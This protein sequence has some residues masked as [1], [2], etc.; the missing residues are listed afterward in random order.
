MSG[1]LALIVFLFQLSP[2]FLPVLGTLLSSAV[3]L[4]VA[5]S[6]IFLRRQGFLVYIGAAFMLICVSPM[7]TV[8][9]LLTTGLSGLSLGLCYWRKP[10]FTFLISSF[11][12]AAGMFCLTYAAGN[13]TLN[14]LFRNMPILVS[15]PFFAVFSMIYMGVWLA[16]LKRLIKLPVFQLRLQNN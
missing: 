11:T 4:S 2:L 9:Y 16:I 10:V 3:T 8:E 13:I 1:L 12:L 5:C 15:I 14:N 7:I 6:V